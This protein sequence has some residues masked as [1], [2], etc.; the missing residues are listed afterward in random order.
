MANVH[1]GEEILPKRSTSSVPLS[2]V[3]Q[4]YRQT[5]ANGFAIAKTRT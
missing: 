4:R 5:I 3:H 2:S 1:S